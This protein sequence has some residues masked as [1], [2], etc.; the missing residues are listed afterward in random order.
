VNSV[1]ERMDGLGGLLGGSGLPEELTDLGFDPVDQVDAERLVRAVSSD[2]DRQRLVA[3]VAAQLRDGL[4]RFPGEPGPDPWS[5][6]D[7]AADPYGAGALALLAL[8]ATVGDLRRFHRE[9]NVPAALA[10]AT[11]TELGQQVRVHRQTFGRF[12]LHTYRWLRHTW[13][14][15]LYWLGRLQFNLE[16][17][18]EGWVCSTH[19]PQTGPLSPLAVDEAFAQAVPFFPRYFPEYPV[20]DFWCA[21]WLLDPVLAG[22]LSPASNIARFQHRWDLY[23]DP[24]PGD[25]DAVFFTFAR[26]GKVDLAALPRRTSL[27]RVV[28]DRLRAGDHWSVWRGRIPIGV[29]HS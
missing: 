23:G 10:A 18:D 27:E 20:T 9:R 22:A 3:L 29:Q 21:S 12:G 25:E 5:G 2:P 6:Y 19:I 11:L 7:S 14:G 13:S 8:L 26:R 15:S 1:S 16:L 17:L 24:M 4:G 28:G